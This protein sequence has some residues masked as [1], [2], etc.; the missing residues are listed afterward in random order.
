MLTIGSNSYDEYFTGLIDEIRIY[1]R[2][3]GVGEIQV[4]MGVAPVLGPATD[5]QPASRGFVDRQRDGQCLVRDV[6]R[7]RR[8]R[9]PSRPFQAR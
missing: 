6:R 4:D 9:S 3:L 8:S 1:N 2:A 7:P 5:H